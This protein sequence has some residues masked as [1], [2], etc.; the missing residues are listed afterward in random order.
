MKKILITGSNGL[1]G[2]KLVRAVGDK[3]EFSAVAVS[4]G[5]CRVQN[6]GVPYESLDITDRDR[7]AEVLGRHRPQTII[8]TAAL[9]HVDLCEKEKDLCWKVNVEAVEELV[10]LCQKKGI[11]LIHLST[12]FIFDG[13]AGPYREEDK[14]N[15]LS[16][17]AESKWESEKVVSSSR[18]PWTIVRTILLYGAGENLGRTNIVLWAKENLEKGRPIQV[19]TD[20]FRAPTLAE[21]LAGACLAAASKNATGIFHVAGKDLMSIIELVKKVAEVFKFDPSLIEPTTSEALG[22]AAR[23]PAN[24]G[25]VIDKAVKVL[26]Y[27]PHSFREGLEIVK[28]QLH[29]STPHPPLSPKGRGKG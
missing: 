20:Q 19:V 13:K 27:Q 25:F 26:G 18:K 22:Q 15:P 2:Q 5:D 24:T 7:L 4:K 28:K 14:P 10:S 6:P 12:D 17:Y 21:D 1:L 8:H 16:H 29:S 3:K 11:H 9:T 23:R